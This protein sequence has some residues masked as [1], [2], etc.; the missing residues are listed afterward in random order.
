MRP[1]GLEAIRGTQ[2]ALMGVIAPELQSMFVQDTGQTL[3]MLLES[4]ANEWDTA[5]ENLSADNRRLVELL[6]QARAAIQSLPAGDDGLASL[7]EEIDRGLDDPPNE[8]LAISYLSARHDRLGALVERTLV[9]CEDAVGRPKFEPLMP[10]RGA[11]YGHLRGVAARGWSFWDVF[12]FR[13]RMARL[14]AGS[15]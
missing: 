12:G 3:Q 2:A 13:E 14:R 15:D 8:S 6:T 7:A 5:A 1:T 9:A 11:I 10:V 4:L